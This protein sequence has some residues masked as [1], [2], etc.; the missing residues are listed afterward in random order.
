[1]LSAALTTCCAAVVGVNLRHLNTSDSLVVLMMM[2]I[3]S[4][5]AFTMFATFRVTRIAK[6]YRHEQAVSALDESEKDG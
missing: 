5:W 3:P 1:M 2:V 4:A 6:A